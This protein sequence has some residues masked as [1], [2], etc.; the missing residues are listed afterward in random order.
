M[1]D[2]L[3]KSNVQNQSIV[4]IPAVTE[5]ALARLGE[6]TFTDIEDEIKLNL[7]NAL[8]DI[9]GEPISDEAFTSI[10]DRF[11]N[12]LRATKRLADPMATTNYR[13][14]NIDFIK[15]YLTKN[16][17]KYSVLLNNFDTIVIEM[18][19]GTDKTVNSPSF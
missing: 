1:E 18:Q 11:H 13:S 6:E 19:K 10:A 7:D 2:V 4:Q 8:K 14:N 9:D 3:T 16:S 15:A 12:I 5:N 17:D